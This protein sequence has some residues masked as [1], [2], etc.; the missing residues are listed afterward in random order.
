MARASPVLAALQE[1]EPPKGKKCQC[2]AWVQCGLRGK[3][4]KESL[5]VRGWEAAQKF[6]REWE[7]GGKA[8]AVTAR[9]ECKR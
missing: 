5:S 1:K 3:W 9:D 7:A 8:S 4:M 2:P 6:V